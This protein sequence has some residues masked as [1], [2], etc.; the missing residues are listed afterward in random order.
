MDHESLIIPLIQPN[1]TVHP[2]ALFDAEEDVKLLHK[3]MKGFGT[4][5]AAI[6]AVLCHRSSQQRMEIVK[7]FKASYGKVNS[8]PQSEKCS[9]T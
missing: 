7:T 1:P 9:I 2:C 4:N 6:I 3:A 8:R 5:E